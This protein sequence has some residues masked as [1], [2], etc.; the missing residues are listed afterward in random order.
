LRLDQRKILNQSLK[1]FPSS[2]LA[3]VPSRNKDFL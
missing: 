1:I 3:A 2:L